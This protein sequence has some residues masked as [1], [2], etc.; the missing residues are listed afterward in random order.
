MLTRPTCCPA[1]PHRVSTT[2]LLA[3]LCALWPRYML[4]CVCLIALD[5][6]S[7]WFQMY[8]SLLSGASTHKVGNNMQTC[9]RKHTCLVKAY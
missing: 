5:I 9:P 3:L 8:A 6:F 1:S 2:G 7:H 4:P